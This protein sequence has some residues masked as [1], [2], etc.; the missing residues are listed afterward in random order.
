MSIA[1]TILFHAATALAGYVYAV[2]AEWFIHKYAFHKIGK[3]KGSPFQFHWSQHHKAVHKHEGGDP[4]YEGSVMRWNAYGREF[5]FIMLGIILHAPIALFAPAAWV[6]MSVSGLNY[7]RCHRKS[8][9]DLTWCRERL[10]W[11]WDHHMGDRASSE[12]NWCV[13]CE[14]F[15]RLMGTRVRYNSE[16]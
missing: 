5:W 10:P 6:A 13:T 16:P 12:A 11:H 14:W 9:I 1:T 2:A 8:H 3:R 7:H 4:A 15:D